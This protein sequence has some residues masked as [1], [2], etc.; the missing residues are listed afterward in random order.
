[1]KG[2]AAWA[3]TDDVTHVYAVPNGFADANG[4][5]CP[6]INIYGA[7]A[8]FDLRK[9]M[10]KNPVR[11]PE[12]RLISI[13]ATSETAANSVVVAWLWLEYPNGGACT[14]APGGEAMIRR[15]WEHGAALV[16]VTAAN[17][18]D[19]T[20]LVSGKKYYLAAV[21]QAAVNGATAGCVGPAFIKIRNSEYQGAEAWLPLINNASYSAANG[22][23]L[24][25]LIEMDLKQ[26]IING[27][28]IL[29]TAGLGYTAE[30]PQAEL[31]FIVDKV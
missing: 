9:A 14:T 19:I 8:S 25:D 10:L 18:T 11:I 7:T 29:Q 6:Y 5:P 15:A 17:S 20:T 30:Q 13:Y 16:S 24:L 2:F 26:P 21:G 31:F 4:I 12:N 23:G 28:N 1:M 22:D 27:G 3:S